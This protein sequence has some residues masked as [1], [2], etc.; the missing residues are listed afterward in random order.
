MLSYLD[1]RD[2]PRTMSVSVSW[3]Q[4]CGYP[5]L[6]KSLYFQEGWTVAED[7]ILNFEDWLQQ[8]QLQFDSQ[9][10]LYWSTT[11]AETRREDIITM[12]SYQKLDTNNRSC[13]YEQFFSDLEQILKGTWTY[14]ALQKLRSRLSGKQIWISAGPFYRTAMF[15]PNR[16]GSIRLQTG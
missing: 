10:E 4:I 6:W 2:L 8:L 3:Y 12:S 1:V 14:S 16:N 7:T 9:H 5:L 11:Y 15:S 13:L